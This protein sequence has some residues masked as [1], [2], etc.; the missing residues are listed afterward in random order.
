MEAVTFIYVLRLT[1]GK[2]YVGKTINPQTRWISHKIVARGGK[3]KYPEKNFAIHAALA[4]YGFQNFSFNLIEYHST[5]ESANEAEKYWISYLKESGMILYNE[6]LG[7][8]GA[9]PGIKFTEE[10]KNKISQAHIGRKAT[11]EARANMSKS[12]KFKFAGVKNNKAKINEFI[13]KEIRSLYGTGKYTH[14]Q[15]A[16]LFN[17]T[18]STIGKIIRYELWP[19]II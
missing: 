16:T 18:H 19:H 4:K 13:V 10:H 1:G 9:S 17:L 3:D 14:R 2:F 7:G 6:T 5:N 8:D 12:K 15:L 11:P